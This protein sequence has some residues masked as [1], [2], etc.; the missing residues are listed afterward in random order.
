MA[1]YVV[2]IREAHPSDGWQMASNVRE[3]VV[4][5]APKSLGELDEVAGAC[6]RRLG[7]EIPALIDDVDDA[8]ESAYT[9][10]PD[11]LYVIGRDGRVVY[12][13]APGPYGFD[14]SGVAATLKRLA[15]S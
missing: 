8:V 2:Y 6:V 3:Q 4:F 13:S 12:K 14:P 1:F 5:R 7:I 11:R 9:G 10:W 15:G